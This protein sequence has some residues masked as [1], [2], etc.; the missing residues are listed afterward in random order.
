MEVIAIECR[1]FD[2]IKCRFESFAKQVKQWCESDQSSEEWL[3]NQGVCTLLNISKRTLQYYRNNGKLSFSQVNNK[4]YYK[5]AVVEKMLKDS[6]TSK[7]N[8]S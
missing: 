3:D 4:C 1:T 6:L 2:L 7:Q 8:K 5:K